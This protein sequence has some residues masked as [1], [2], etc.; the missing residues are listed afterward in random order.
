MHN[1]IIRDLY[2]SL[3]Q[4]DQVG[5]PHKKITGRRREPRRHTLQNGI[6]YNMVQYQSISIDADKS[7]N[8]EI[9]ALM[10]AKSHITLLC[11]N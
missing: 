5:I 3:G 8:I 7:S 11:G 4:P 2:H 10:S 1:F 6:D 9:G